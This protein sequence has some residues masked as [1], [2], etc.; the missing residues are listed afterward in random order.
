[1]KQAQVSSHDLIDGCDWE[2]W[3][4]SKWTLELRFSPPTLFMVSW[5]NIFITKFGLHSGKVN[6][7]LGLRLWIIAWSCFEGEAQNKNLI[8]FLNCSLIWKYIRML[9][10]HSD[11]HLLFPP[12]HY[13][14]PFTP[15]VCVA[16]DFHAL[17]SFFIKEMVWHFRICNF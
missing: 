16:Y 2:L 9:I 1:M 14:N 4:I 3:I 15:T 11:I 12:L 6:I 8:Q 7:W 17:L 10:H 5:A 13:L